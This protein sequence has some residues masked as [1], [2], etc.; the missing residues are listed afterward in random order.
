MRKKLMIEKFVR[1]TKDTY[2]KETTMVR[3]KCGE[4]DDFDSDLANRS[5]IDNTTM[6]KIPV[7]NGAATRS[8]RKRQTARFHYSTSD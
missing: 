7:S 8:E 6:M 3:S 1:L 2:D 4:M 5:M